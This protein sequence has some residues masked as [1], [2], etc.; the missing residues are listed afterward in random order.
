[1][2]LSLADPQPHYELE[3]YNS[4][5]SSFLLS[6][7]FNH[8]FSGPIGLDGVHRTGKPTSLQ[9][10]GVTGVYALKGS[11]RD[12]STFVIDRL[13]LGLGQ[14]AEHWLLTFNGEKLKLSLMM[15]N[16]EEVSVDGTTGE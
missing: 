1:V 10:L 13:L 7:S 16:G 5:P 15:L 11:W 4:P 12:D 2:S 9:G 6:I 14:P 8:R 3:F